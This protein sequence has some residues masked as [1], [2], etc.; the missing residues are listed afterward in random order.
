[1]TAYLLASTV[2]GPL[3]G[4]L[5][6][7]YGRKRLLQA[8]I[9]IFLLGSA[10]CGLAQNMAELIAFRALQGLGG[11]GLMVTTIAVIGDIVPPR[12]RGR[13]QGFFGAVFGVSTVV[14]PLL[15]GFFVD[16]LSWRWIFYINLPIGLVALVVIG[17]DVPRACRHAPRIDYLGAACW[18]PG[19][20]D[21]PVHD[22]GGTTY[23]WGRREII[24]LGVLAVVLLVR[25]PVRR[26]RAAE[27]VIPLELFRNRV[28]SGHERDRVHRRLRAVRR[29]HLPAALPPGRQGRQPRRVGAAAA[30]ADGRRARHVDRQRPADHE[31]GR[32]KIF[33]IVG[34]ALMT[35]ACSCSR[36]CVDTP[37]RSALH[38]GP[39]PRPRPGH[40]GA[41]ARRAE[42]GRLPPAR[43]RDLRLHPLPPDRRLVRRR[44]LR[45]DLR[46]PARRR[47]RRPPAARR[48]RPEAANPAV[49]DS[50]RRRSTRLYVDAFATA[51]RPVF[52]VAAA[53]RS[54]LRPTW[55]L[56]EVPLRR[57]RGSRRPP[58]PSRR[59]P[60]RPSPSARLRPS[61]RRRRAAAPTG[62]AP[63][64]GSAR[65]RS[66][67]RAVPP[68][69]GL[70]RVSRA[71]S[72]RSR[73]GSAPR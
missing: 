49:A 54:S 30:A 45:R 13:Y 62:A 10:L 63:S 56:R 57:R 4:K 60:R 36:G 72:G 39:R 21:R 50:C 65:S 53:I 8:A 48:A 51:L 70:A 12:E 67:C 25:V 3:Y 20:G 17:A 40:A 27:P 31:V 71:R 7:L 47:A 32:Y 26:A 41:G 6:D 5:G 23:A 2:V 44:G 52:L 34:T 43:R 66:R 73:R 15:G 58:T 64:R 61:R 18:R 22:L 37:L 69:R 1:M 16:N 33:P 46:Q 24:A 42:R 68:A 19:H 28:F 29:D 11:G 9:V 14:G 35:S 59:R 55:L 38:A